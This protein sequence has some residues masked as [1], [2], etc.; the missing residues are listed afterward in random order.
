MKLFLLL[1]VT[2]M[3]C[4][5]IQKKE[6]SKNEER[7]LNMFGFGPYHPLFNPTLSQYTNLHHTIPQNGGKTTIQ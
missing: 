3:Q 7:E 5:I 1:L 2:S 6:E 4:D